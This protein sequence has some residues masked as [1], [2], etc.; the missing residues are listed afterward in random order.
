M[1]SVVAATPKSNTGRCPQKALI[2]SREAKF[3]KRVCV[4]FND[5][6]RNARRGS[7]RRGGAARRR[8]RRIEEEM[9]SEDKP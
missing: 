2:V 9:K 4:T 8:R 3:L 5:T 7:R 1:P 6:A